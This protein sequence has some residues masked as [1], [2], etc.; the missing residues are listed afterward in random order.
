MKTR[1][2]LALGIL[3][4][5]LCLAACGSPAAP[6]T[7][8]PTTKTPDVPKETATSEP[9]QQTSPPP[10]IPTPTCETIISEGTVR[11][12]QEQGWTYEQREFRIGDVPVE[13]GLECMWADYTTAS[14]HGQ[15]YAWGLLS[16]E[17]SRTAQA[18]LQ[19]DGW[20]RSSEDGRTYFTEDPA[21]AIAVD[22]E[23]YGM[24][25]EF[26]DGWVKFADTKQG[27]LLIEW[28]D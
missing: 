12:L 2:P 19:T 9:V 22:D 7:T 20:L 27:L 24:T 14:D 1:L 18:G 23:G 6:G 21:Y 4:T 11:A 13:S 8:A 16:S 15:M 25:Y 10:T 28:G 26:G 17:Q 3:L 5:A